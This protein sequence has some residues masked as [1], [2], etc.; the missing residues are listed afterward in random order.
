MTRVNCCYINGYFIVLASYCLQ[1]L[2]FES[3]VGGAGDKSQ[4]LTRKPV[5]GPLINTISVNWCQK[6]VD[7]AILEA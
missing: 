5:M 6:G 4:E 1:I 3:G 7:M 2:M